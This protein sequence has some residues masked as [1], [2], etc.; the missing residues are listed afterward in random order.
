MQLKR[1]EDQRKDH[2]PG[3]DPG[4]FLKPYSVLLL[5]AHAGIGSRGVG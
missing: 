5:A 4:H 3:L 1:T 2:D